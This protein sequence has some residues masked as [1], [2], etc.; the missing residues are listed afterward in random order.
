MLDRRAGAVKGFSQNS[1][2][3]SP[4]WSLGK[5]PVNPADAIRPQR[6]LYGRE[7]VAELGPTKPEDL[8]HL[9]VTGFAEPNGKKPAPPALCLP[10]LGN[11]S[12]V[13]M[14]KCKPCGSEPKRHVPF[15][16][17]GNGRHC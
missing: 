8:R 7:P 6:I 10:Y 9:M 12:E 15:F 3:R 1:G 17:S 11:L 5:L 4:T 14:G 2:G 16:C 13:K